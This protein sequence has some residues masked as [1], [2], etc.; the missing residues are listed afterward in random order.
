MAKID[1][2]TNPL[3]GELTFNAQDK[4]GR[5][6]VEK[7]KSVRFLPTKSNGEFRVLG[8]DT[9]YENRRA[10]MNAILRFAFN[11]DVV[12][13]PLHSYSNH[14]P[15]R[16]GGSIGWLDLKGLKAP[17]NG[18]MPI[19]VDFRYNYKPVR[20]T[21]PHRVVN[22]TPQEMVLLS[23]GHPINLDNRP[24]KGERVS[25]VYITD[26]WVV[27]KEHA[28]GYL[29]FQNAPIDRKTGKN[30]GGL[31]H[32]YIA[33]LEK[34]VQITVV[35]TTTNWTNP[36]TGETI[37]LD[38]LQTKAQW[39]QRT[40]EVEGF[41]WDAARKNLIESNILWK[42]TQEL[43]DKLSRSDEEAGS[44]KETKDVLEILDHRVN[45]GDE[46][47][48]SVGVVRDGKIV[49]VD[50]TKVLPGVYAVVRVVNGQEAGIEKS[51]VTISRFNGAKI[52]RG[53]SRNNGLA[54]K[55]ISLFQS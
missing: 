32:S 44:E 24:A 25:V 53:L 35:V 29:E 2:T 21:L 40:V 4:A 30:L 9:P 54:L 50:A 1:M 51:E 42:N 22:V 48:L 38:G 13:G 43:M 14:N 10:A 20:V 6:E 27:V 52:L 18:T 55:E 17:Q 3:R 16:V 34:G 7:I 39:L 41:N 33:D 23:E 36:E 12:T 19:N 8:P 45:G 15:S 31:L 49:P 37:V 47:G 11:M 26:P 46:V 28:T 5:P